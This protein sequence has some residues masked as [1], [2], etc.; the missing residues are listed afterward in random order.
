MHFADLV[1][2]YK[3]AAT[4]RKILIL[5][6]IAAILPGFYLADNFSDYNDRYIA[7]QNARDQAEK[8][9][10][11]AREERDR[12]PKLEE[13]LETTEK[14]L[15]LASKQLP[16]QFQ[17]ELIL[18]KVSMM[19]S[20]SGVTLE[21]FTPQD[22]KVTGSAFPYVE[23]PIHIQA[24]GTF[25]RI[26]T[27]F[28]KIVHL[29]MMVH[30]R[31]MDLIGEMSKGSGLDSDKMESAEKRS[32]RNPGS[33]RDLYEAKRKDIRV[34]ATAKLMIFRS[35]TE[36]ETRRFEESSEPHHDKHVPVKKG[37]KNA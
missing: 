35:L 17:M 12:L 21:V 16:N 27:F 11:K 22:A 30:I 20:D 24:R 1:I 37:P 10:K 26:T 6:A 2:W 5:A 29:E 34:A 8:K 28:D 32:V 3:N 31:D 7:S 19:A 15:A 25:G 36:D 4:S 23:L 18:Q 33:N 13:K 9:F 14:E